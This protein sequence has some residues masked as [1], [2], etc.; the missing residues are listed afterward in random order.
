MLGMLL[1]KLEGKDYDISSLKH[2]S[3]IDHPSNI[4]KLKKKAKAEFWVGFGQSETTGM[5]TVCAHTEKPGSAGK[6]GPWRRSNWL[7]I[8]TV[9]FRSERRERSASAAP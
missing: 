2:V 5:V 6:E 4:E 9:K 3:G 8:T 1:E 7:T